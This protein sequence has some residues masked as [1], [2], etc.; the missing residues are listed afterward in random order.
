MSPSIHQASVRMVTCR[1]QH[2]HLEGRKDSLTLVA[3][4]LSTQ[5]MEFKFQRR[6]GRPCLLILHTEV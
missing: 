4:H 5:M 6:E 1:E 3:L 2:N